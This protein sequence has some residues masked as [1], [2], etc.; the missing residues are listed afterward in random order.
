MNRV[1]AL[2]LNDV[3]VFVDDDTDP[4][5]WVDLIVHHPH[6]PACGVDLGL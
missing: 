3:I 1:V 6:I 4:V 5:H 2:Q